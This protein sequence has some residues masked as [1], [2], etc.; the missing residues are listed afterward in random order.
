MEL[1]YL[2]NMRTFGNVLFR[3]L[4]PNGL[5]TTLNT[6][7]YT[8]FHNYIV[9]TIAVRSCAYPCD[10][11]ISED[12]KQLFSVLWS[13]TVAIGSIHFRHLRK[14][15]N[16]LCAPSMSVTKIDD[17]KCVTNI[18]MSSFMKKLAFFIRS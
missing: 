12:K 15:I 11:F 8:N 14:R 13:V 18:E 10:S 1:N 5:T 3:D 9:I 2:I 17:T 6:P 4:D 16:E 7:I